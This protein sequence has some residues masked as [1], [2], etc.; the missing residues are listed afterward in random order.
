MC[1]FKWWFQKESNGKFRVVK[2]KKEKMHYFLFGGNWHHNWPN[3][4]FFFFLIMLVY[5]VKER[6]GQNAEP[7][8][9]NDYVSVNNE[10][11]RNWVSA[12]V[13]GRI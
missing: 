13:S 10:E 4:N 3:N 12:K 8:I 5:Y 11:G 1:G 2:K 9:A 6:L 7:R